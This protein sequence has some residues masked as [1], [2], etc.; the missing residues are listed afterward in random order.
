[1]AEHIPCYQEGPCFAR[2]PGDRK[3]CTLLREA[4]PKGAFV[5]LPEAL[6]KLHKRC[7]L[8]AGSQLL[9]RESI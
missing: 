1:M 5:S 2:S 6:K 3:K 7:T 4:Y 9:Q 8:W